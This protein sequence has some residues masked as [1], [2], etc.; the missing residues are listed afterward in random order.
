VWKRARLAARLR[1]TPE[2]RTE[3]KSRTDSRIGALGSG[4]DY[5]VFIDH[6]GVPSANLGYGG[7]DQG[8]G[9]Y[10]SVYDDFYYY[11]HFQD[12]DFVYGR[13]LAQTAGTMMMR[14]ADADILPYQFTDQADTIR[15][16]VT[17]VKKLADTMRTQI[18]DRNADLADGVY[19]A[20]ADPKKTSVPP[21]VDVVPPYFNFAPL[22]QASD[23]LTAAAA[24]YEKAFT[25]HADNV[26]PKVNVLLISTEHALTDPAGLP[27]RPWFENMVYA[28]GFFTG[29]G[30][31]TL[32][33]VREAIEQKQWSAV[34]PQI[35]R[36]AAAIERE[37]DKLKAATNA[38]NGE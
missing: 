21:P 6:L 13:A 33:A 17:E 31:K 38:L 2:M 28:P 22:D 11:T 27:N 1:G 14:M 36:T 35:A 7:E 32:P 4:S 25:A 9:Q 34:D 29:Y 30:V 12:T 15:T 10:H 19:K 8:G 23:D 5:T 16:Y 3:A 26:D 20:A 37:T 24:D 18:K